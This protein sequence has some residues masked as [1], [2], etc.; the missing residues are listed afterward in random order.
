LQFCD[1]LLHSHFGIEGKEKERDLVE[2]TGEGNIENIASIKQWS[3]RTNI[4]KDV[5]IYFN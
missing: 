4:S 3:K 2:K 1:N 5:L